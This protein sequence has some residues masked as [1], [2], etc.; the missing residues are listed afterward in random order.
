MDSYEAIEEIEAT[1]SSS[2]NDKLLHICNEYFPEEDF[3]NDLNSGMVDDMYNLILEEA[4]E[5]KKSA[6]DIYFFL[7]DE[8][9]TI[10]EDDF[11]TEEEIN[12]G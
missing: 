6:E 12:H 5:N 7:L 10:D 2:S 11:Y 4:N 1:L 3:G 8:K 9:I